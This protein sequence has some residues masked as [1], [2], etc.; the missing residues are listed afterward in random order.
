MWSFK[1]TKIA[2]ILAFTRNTQIIWI[3]VLTCGILFIL[4]DLCWSVSYRSV[5][6]LV[7]FSILIS[8]EFE[9]TDRMLTLNYFSQYL[10]FLSVSFI[11]IK[12]YGAFVDLGDVLWCIIFLD[13]WQLFAVVHIGLTIWLVLFLV[14][15]FTV[16]NFVILKSNAWICD[17]RVVLR[18]IVTLNEGGTEVEY[19]RLWSSI[20]GVTCVGPRINFLIHLH[21]L[22]LVGDKTTPEIVTWLFED[23]FGPKGGFEYLLLFCRGCLLFSRIVH[24]LNWI[25]IWLLLWSRWGTLLEGFLGDFESGDPRVFSIVILWWTQ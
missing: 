11:W 8:L 5:H 6:V 4:G 9:M 25:W 14:L 2:A 21:L 22:V 10:D 17:A 18:L 20:R 7:I 19:L 13:R 16:A 1:L 12:T 23:R 24:R 3:F 15:K